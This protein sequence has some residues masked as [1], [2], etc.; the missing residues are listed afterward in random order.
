[1]NAPAASVAPPAEVDLAIEG[2]TC[3]ACASR[4]E[5]VLNRLPQ[6]AATVNFAA[7]RAHVAYNP[8]LTGTDGLIQAIRKAGYDAHPPID[9]SEDDAQREAA[10]RADFRKLVVA[11]VLT[12]PLV[13]QMIPMALGAHHWMLPNWLQ[14]V[15]ATPVQFWIGARFYVGAWHALRGGSANMDVL[16]A[17]GTSAA[18]FYSAA[19]TLGGGGHVYFEA[20]AAIITLVLLGKYLEAR[21]RRR[22]S[23][24]IRELMR[25]QPALARIERDGEPVEVPV[26]TIRAGDIFH[27]RAGDSVPVDGEVIEGTSTID[28]SMLTGESQA[29][30][31]ATGA[32]VYAGTLNADGFL[33]CRATSV[34]DRT[35]LAAIIRLVEQAQGSKAPIQ[36][37]ADRISAIFVPAVLLLALATWAGWML[38]GA[39][40]ADALVNAVAVLVIACPCALG[41]ATP[42]AIMVGTGRG[43]HAGILVKNAAA[44][45]HAGRLDMLAVDK[46]GTLT[47]GRPEVVEVQPLNASEA[48]DILRIAA[49]LE[50]GSSHPLGTAIRRAAEARGLTPFAITRFESHAGRGVS[51]EIDGRPALLGSPEHLA[52]H[53][54]APRPDV[55]QTL[56]ARG[57]TV[58]AVGYDGRCLGLLGLADRIRASSRAAVSRLE[59]MGVEVVMLTG[60]NEAAAAEIGKEAG[61]SRIRAKVLPA[62]KAHEIETARARGRIVGMVGDGINDAPAL[63]AADVSFAIGAGT[64]VAIQTADV[65]LMRSDLTGVVDAIALSRATLAKVRQNLFFAFF[66]NV[67]GIPLAALGMLNPVVAGAAMALS[68]VSVVSNSLL[69]RRWRPRPL[70]ATART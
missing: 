29:V 22:A 45:E 20:S 55:V 13:A 67:L 15:L 47:E 53:G 39:S 54:L 36:R 56:A 40:A 21:A 34:G 18:W 50:H 64:D 37:L 10:S 28:E 65:T 38:A 49:S 42:T 57:R 25:L 41:L 59:A 4:I 58:V 35:A 26:A 8:A 43:A 68:S 31:K 2:M 16:I 66:Y 70:A 9:A 1:M 52:Q 12:A 48:D 33:R 17:L 61:V 62:D 19:V 24:A 27:L 11:A 30:A 14:L 46:T 63:A 69:L 23:S 3:A 5:K 44:L 60:D 32:R 7:E 51:A 6:V